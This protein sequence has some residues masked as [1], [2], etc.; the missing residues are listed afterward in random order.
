ML[1][2]TGYF[3]GVSYQILASGQG[4]RRRTASFLAFLLALLSWFLVGL[5]AT[6]GIAGDCVEPRDVMNVSSGNTGAKY[7]V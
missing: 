3:D 5:V 6:A 1:R 2:L 7:T 4:I